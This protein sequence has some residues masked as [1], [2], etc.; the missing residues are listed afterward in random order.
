MAYEYWDT[1]GQTWV[2]DLATATGCFTAADF[3]Y[4]MLWIAKTSSVDEDLTRWG[5]TGPDPDIDPYFGRA[6]FRAGD[7]GIWSVDTWDANVLMGLSLVAG[8]QDTNPV[9]LPYMQGRREVGV[10]GP[11]AQAAKDKIVVGTRIW[12]RREAPAPPP[13]TAATRLCFALP[14]GDISDELPNVPAAA[15]G[16]GMAF[17]TKNA[18]ISISDIA[19]MAGRTSVFR[20]VPVIVGALLATDVDNGWRRGFFKATVPADLRCAQFDLGAQ[21]LVKDYQRDGNSWADHAS[22]DDCFEL[23]PNTGFGTGVFRWLGAT[24]GGYD[25]DLFP[26]GGVVTVVAEGNTHTGVIGA[27]IVR[28]FGSLGGGY[29]WAEVVFSPRLD[30]P[31]ADWSS[32]TGP[33]SLAGSCSDGPQ[34]SP[35]GSSVGGGSCGLR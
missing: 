12:L 20:R 29:Y 22:P 35:G 8:A 27:P 14:G 21:F 10:F 7:D 33:Y 4:D 9:S 32:V 6:V 16:A 3:D 31:A 18:G 17:A 25:I 23:S 15:A 1:D 30:V 13:S 26:I 11:V 24:D 2:S 19:R 5:V 34:V 28:S